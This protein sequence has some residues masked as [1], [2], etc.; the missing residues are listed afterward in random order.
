[1]NSL[2]NNGGGPGSQPAG[3]AGNQP[4]NG[5]DIPPDRAA[6]FQPEGGA[7]FQP[8]PNHEPPEPRVAQLLEELKHRNDELDDFVHIASHDLKEPIRGIRNYANFLIEDYA[9]LLGEDGL[10]K[11]RTIDRLGQRA[12]DLLSALLYF[13]QVRRAPLALAPVDTGDLLAEVLRSLHSLIA[14]R[15]ATV[16]VPQPLPVVRCDRIRIGEVFRAL[17]TNALRYNDSPQ[18][19][20]EI[21]CDQGTPERPVFCIRDN[22]IGVPSAHY[23]TIFGIFKRLHARDDYG[24]GTG[25]GLAISKRIVERHGGRI[26]LQSVVGQG[27]MFYFTVGGA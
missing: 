1:M 24:G 15:A 18:P 4:T 12:H 16:A 3:R 14:E 13:S 10:S 26:W 11:L 7:G 21:T 25:S 19:F 27:S 9:P 8:A 5:A 23:E 2:I 6:G 20:A 17:T 22:G